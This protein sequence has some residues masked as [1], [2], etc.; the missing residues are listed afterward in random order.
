MRFACSP[1]CVSVTVR[2]GGEE[3]GGD[4]LFTITQQCTEERLTPGRDS[5][6][7]SDPNCSVCTFGKVLP[8]AGLRA[9][10]HPH[11]V[12]A[13]SGLCK[14]SGVALLAASVLTEQLMHAAGSSGCSAYNAFLVRNQ[15]T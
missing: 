1:F 2:E 13:A 7:D 3:G 11:G 14:Q 10:E 8:T 6:D 15:C 5:P 4:G 9:K 12:Y